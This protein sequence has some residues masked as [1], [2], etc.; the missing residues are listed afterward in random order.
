MYYCDCPLF[1]L[2]DA[3]AKLNMKKISKRSKFIAHQPI[4]VVCLIVVP[5]VGPVPFHSCLILIIFTTISSCLLLA[6]SKDFF[7]KW[8]WLIA[9]GYWPCGCRV[10]GKSQNSMTLLCIIRVILT[11]FRKVTFWYRNKKHI[12]LV[13]SSFIICQMCYYICFEIRHI[14]FIK[15]QKKSNMRK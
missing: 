12:L 2:L 11:Y 1:Y 10:G 5:E 15:S 8:S 14:C 7:F 6:T 3:I 9:I 4:L 13:F